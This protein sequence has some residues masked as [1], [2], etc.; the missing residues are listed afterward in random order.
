MRSGGVKGEFIA[1]PGGRSPDGRP[2]AR[3]W[4]PRVSVPRYIPERR[5]EF[6]RRRAGRFRGQLEIAVFARE[7]GSHARL[8]I[9]RGIC[10]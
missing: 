4:G 8:I 7:N 10:L 1:P 2:S 6:L 3:W 5:S 9:A